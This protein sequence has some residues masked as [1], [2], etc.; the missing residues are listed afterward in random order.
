V[1]SRAM[2]MQYHAKPAAHTAQLVI[3]KRRKG[4]AKKKSLTVSNMVE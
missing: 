3:T 4:S 1:I 2:P